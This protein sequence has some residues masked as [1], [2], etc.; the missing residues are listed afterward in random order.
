MK[1]FYLLATA[2]TATGIYD[3]V[4]LPACLQF[5]L[6]PPLHH[7]VMQ[8]SNTMVDPAADSKAEQSSSTSR[9]TNIEMALDNAKEA[10]L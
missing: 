9:R 1:V 5:I 7:H 8:M 2:L 10:V 3:L 4:R 6:T